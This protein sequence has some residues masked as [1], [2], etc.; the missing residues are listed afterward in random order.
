MSHTQT[1]LRVW[2][3][4]LTRGQG[5]SVAAFCCLSQN[6]HPHERMPCRAAP[7]PL[8]RST[9]S[10]RPSRQG[11]SLRFFTSSNVWPFFLPNRAR[12]QVM[13]PTFLS[14]LAVRRLR[15][16]SYLREKQALVRLPP[17]A[18]TSSPPLLYRRWMKDEMWECWLQPL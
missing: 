7:V 16:C 13:S 10:V 18:R 2:L 8:P 14:R 12:S 11:H 1:F 9:S 5:H 17:L 3:K 6:S 4:D 15:L